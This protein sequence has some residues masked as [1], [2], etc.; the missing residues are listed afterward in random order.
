[1]A[2]PSPYLTPAECTAILANY[3]ETDAFDASTTL[4]QTQAINSA[5]LAIDGLK[6]LEDKLVETQD[7]EF[8]RTG[9]TAVPE[10]I[11]T[12]VAFE[13]NMLLD[14]KS[15]EQEAE[16]MWLESQTYAGVSSSYKRDTSP[17]NI[18]SAIMSNM[19]WN[20]LKPYLASPW[21]LDIDIS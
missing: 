3:L 11:L 17:D 1:M 12:A 20:I 10:E 13:A 15:T 18:A 5:T 4:E 19:A 6:Y 14:G 2:L 7:N 8:P 9:M 21:D 16:S